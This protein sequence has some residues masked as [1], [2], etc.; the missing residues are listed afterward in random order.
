MTNISAA[1][2]QEIAKIVKDNASTSVLIL[3]GVIIAL[4]FLKPI[5]MYYIQAKYN[6]PP[7][8]EAILRNIKSIDDNVEGND[9]KSSKSL[10]GTKEFVYHEP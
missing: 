7:P 5:V 3:E 9:I 6:A 10:I 4:S 1:D 2:F 8:H